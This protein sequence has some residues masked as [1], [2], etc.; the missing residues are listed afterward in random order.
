MTEQHNNNESLDAFDSSDEVPVYDYDI[1]KFHSSDDSF[2]DEGMEGDDFILV[3]KAF[4][5]LLAD[6]EPLFQALKGLADRNYDLNNMTK[7][8][9]SADA[10]KD[11]VVS[12]HCTQKTAY[13]HFTRIRIPDNFA[14]ISRNVYSKGLYG[15]NPS[16]PDFSDF[17]VGNCDYV[18]AE[19]L[20]ENAAHLKKINDL[21][22]IALTKT[23]G[24]GKTKGHV[25]K[26][27]T[28]F[29][30]GDVCTTKVFE[31]NS[32]SKLSKS[33]G[34][35]Y[36][37][38][39]AGTLGSSD[40]LLARAAARLQ[41]KVS[42][43]KTRTRSPVLEYYYCD[44][45]ALNNM[46]AF[47]YKVAPQDMIGD[48]ATNLT[49][50]SL[51][52]SFTIDEFLSLRKQIYVI[53]MDMTI[54]TQVKYG[55]IVDLLEVFRRQLAKDE[56]TDTEVGESNGIS[57]VSRA[58]SGFVDSGGPESLYYA[59]DGCVSAPDLFEAMDGRNMFTVSFSDIGTLYGNR[60]F[61]KN[62]SV[63]MIDAASQLYVAFPK[64]FIAKRGAFALVDATQWTKN[65][66]ILTSRVMAYLQ[67]AVRS[68]ANP[69]E[70][71]TFVSTA[72]RN[73]K[74]PDKDKVIKISCVMI[75]K[76]VLCSGMSFVPSSRHKEKVM[77]SSHSVYDNLNDIYGLEDDKFDMTY[78]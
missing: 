75:T 45:H 61:S 11:A 70:I 13:K 14:K 50:F 47:P 10:V 35:G 68:F 8:F 5:T 48:I 6:L 51:T 1:F 16:G 63:Y 32:V 55:M 77:A 52:Y 37:P 41:G 78:L 74:V 54:S 22:R 66:I 67:L 73:V 26:Y 12:V 9:D 56:V 76:S 24:S 53:N 20:K 18:A 42:Y 27:M 29:T 7:K 60:E 39:L 23:A 36:S 4:P 25:K 62:Y 44:Q 58:I 34:I 17:G 72:L 46:K 31:T 38:G 49:V 64:G 43:V 19:Y 71:E 30:A 59:S 3:M 21:M 65:A 2:D 40:Y 28:A 69:G 33:V 15:I 57:V